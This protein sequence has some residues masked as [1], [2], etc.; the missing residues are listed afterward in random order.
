[1][2]DGPNDKP[3]TE[4]ADAGDPLAEAKER[5]ATCWAAIQK[6]LADHNCE[7]RPHLTHE[8]VGGVGG[9]L[10]LTPSYWVAPLPPPKD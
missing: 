5:A 1:M 10:L 8:E 9:K 4:Q 6:V 7:L 2:A 3:T